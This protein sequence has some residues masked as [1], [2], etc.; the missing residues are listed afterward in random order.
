[1]AE[2]QV[3]WM[4]LESQMEYMCVCLFFS[5]QTLFH[6]SIEEKKEYIFYC[7]QFP[8]ISL[9]ASGSNSFCL[10]FRRLTAHFSPPPTSHISSTLLCL[11][12]VVEDIS[13]MVVSIIEYRFSPP[14]QIFYQETN[15]DTKNIML[16][17]IQEEIYQSY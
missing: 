7:Y 10:K 8:P 6:V 1:M 12:R 2:R 3:R 15:P 17:R 4:E 14:P 13:A 16:N 9:S 5:P 11:W